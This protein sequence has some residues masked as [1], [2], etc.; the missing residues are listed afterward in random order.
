MAPART[1]A[2][3]ETR[4]DTKRR[5][6][7]EIDIGMSRASGLPTSDLRLFILRRLDDCRCGRCRQAKARL[8][9]HP[10][11]LAGC[12]AAL[13]ALLDHGAPELIPHVA[14]RLTD[15]GLLT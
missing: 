11:D 12:H 15:A 6:I 10:E 8:A 13:I 5:Q 1:S 14:Q 2:Q 3:T 4:S 9:Q 7:L